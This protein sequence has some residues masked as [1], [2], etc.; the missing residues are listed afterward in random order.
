ML[1]CVVNCITHSNKIRRRNA[2]WKIHHDWQHGQVTGHFFFQLCIVP[3]YRLERSHPSNRHLPRVC[4]W[5]FDSPWAEAQ[6][7]QMCTGLPWPW[8]PGSR[9]SLQN[10][11][12]GQRA[13]RWAMWDP[14]AQRAPWSYRILIWRVK[15]LL[16]FKSVLSKSYFHFA[17]ILGN[18]ASL[19]HATF[20]VNV[21]IS[22][23]TDHVHVTKM[24]WE[25]FL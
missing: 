20:V 23:Y 22:K 18:N 16:R 7:R 12:C 15:L 19:K 25:H 8:P 2:V 11:S 10:L 3:T 4:Q 14:D 13:S 24:K 5:L 1:E 9:C 6:T 21:N 17:S